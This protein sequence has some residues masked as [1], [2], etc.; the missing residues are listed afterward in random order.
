MDDEENSGLVIT[1][2]YFNPEDATKFD[3]GENAR[4]LRIGI[5][6]KMIAII[7]QQSLVVGGFRVGEKNTN[8]LFSYTDYLM[9]HGL[10]QMGMAS[11]EDKGNGFQMTRLFARDEKEMNRLE[12]EVGVYSVEQ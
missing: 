4:G 11:T 2:I 3:L 9:K 12:R 8:Y 5:Y 6:A 10:A 1:K 7:Q